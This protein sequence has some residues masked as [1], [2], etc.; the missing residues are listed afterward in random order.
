MAL[1]IDDLPGAIRQAKKELRAALPNY[2][3][4]FAEVEAAIIA[5][6][7]RIAAQRDRGEDVDLGEGAHGRRLVIG[8]D[9]RRFL[10]PWAPS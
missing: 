7:K 4:V 9:R 8:W 2:R 10:V 6:A 5:E 3:E 1:K